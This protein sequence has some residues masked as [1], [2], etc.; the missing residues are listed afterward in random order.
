MLEMRRRI[1]RIVPNAEEVL[2]YGIATF[3]VNGTIV[4]GLLAAKHHVGFY[5]FSGTVHPRVRTATAAEDPERTS[6]SGSPECWRCAGRS[7]VT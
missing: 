1:L 3:K 7:T 5:P 2:S 6:E 4:G